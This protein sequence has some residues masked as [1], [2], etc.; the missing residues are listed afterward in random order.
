MY[1]L[2]LSTE[3]L[4]IRDTIR[5]FVTREIKPIALKAERLEICDRR[6]PMQ[7]IDQASQMGLRTLALS[8]DRGGAGADHLTC[9]IVTEELAAGD[10]DIAAVLSTTSRL[11]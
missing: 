3:Q 7:L 4:E 9:C 10:A 11:G 2:H 1:N 6:L 8:E 5:D